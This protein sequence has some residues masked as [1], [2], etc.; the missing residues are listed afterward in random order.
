MSDT[1]DVYQMA[2]EYAEGERQSAIEESKKLDIEQLRK[3]YVDLMGMVAY[4]TKLEQLS[5]ATP[6][7]HFDGIRKALKEIG[8]D[9]IIRQARMADEEGI[10]LGQWARVRTMPLLNLL[11]RCQA[12]L[13]SQESYR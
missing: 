13:P 2:R 11:T 5:S 12:M 7:S 3:E 6:R 10:P 1:H 4:Y 8:A 9:Q